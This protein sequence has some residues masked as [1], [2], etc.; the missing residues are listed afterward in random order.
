MTTGRGSYSTSTAAA[1]SAAAYRLVA[2]TAATSWA[3]YI[4]FSTGRTIWVSDMR[5][6]IQWRLYLARS[7]PVITASTPG[8]AS[9][10]ALSIFLIVAWA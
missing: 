2:R 1:P 7:W 10:F 5:V 3:W 9:A 4:T 6:G 8:T